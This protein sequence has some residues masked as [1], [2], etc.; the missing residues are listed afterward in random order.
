[1][2]ENK[3]APSAD[4]KLGLESSKPL[5]TRSR[6]PIYYKL[7]VL[8]AQKIRD[9]E[10]TEGEMIPSE[11]DMTDEYGVSRV[12]VRKALKELEEENLIVRR[13]GA[14]SLVANVRGLNSSPL[15]QGPV[16]NLLTQ[17]L[18]A[19]AQN[20]ETGWSLPPQRVLRA[21][22]LPEQTECYLVRRLRTHSETPFSY[23]Q[24]YVCPDV[25]KP[26]IGVSLDQ[27]PVLVHLERAGF[28][29]SFAEQ[30]IS[31]TLAQDPAAQALCVPLG[32]ALI[33]L[34]RTVFNEAGRPCI[35][36]NSL[37][38]PD[39]YEYYMRLSR[40][41]SSMRPEWRNT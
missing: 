17:G 20:L 41:S 26:I 33:Q 29:A 40:Q 12:T 21:L 7:Y 37:Y 23:S 31:A 25:A 24:V 4:A 8:F 27:Y 18:A 2:N 19:E 16:D 11:I 30:T 38:R 36:Q 34:R 9:G 5:N 32:S 35:Y 28:L 3:T 6:I 1:M 14:R 15:I 13:R 39:K 10:W 22:R